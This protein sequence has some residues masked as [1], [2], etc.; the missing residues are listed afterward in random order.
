M[1]PIRSLS[2]DGVE[3]AVSDF[4]VP[5]MHLSSAR[6]AMTQH[7]FDLTVDSA[8]FTAGHA[9]PFRRWL[10]EV[11]ADDEEYGDPVE[12]A[13]FGYPDLD[14]VL[15]DPAILA[16][17]RDEHILKEWLRKFADH[18]PAPGRYW[19]HEIDDSAV[20]G[21]TVRLSGTC[22]RQPLGDAAAS[23]GGES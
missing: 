8:S 22:Y 15:A 9:A 19:L 3:A 12:L 5:E 17:F 23:A 10:D 20:A 14:R 18:G 4:V 2:I 13:A 6:S 7:R 16:V 1:N 11:R 21:D